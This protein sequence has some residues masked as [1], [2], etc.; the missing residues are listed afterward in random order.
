MINRFDLANLHEPVLQILRGSDEDSMTM[1][2]SLAQNGVQV[3]D[4]CHDSHRH[5]TTVSWCFWARVQSG[6]EPF[7][8]LLDASLELVTLEEDDED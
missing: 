4:S 6:A 1:V 8:N 3:F 5:F 2:L 7:A